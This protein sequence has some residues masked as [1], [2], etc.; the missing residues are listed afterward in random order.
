MTTREQYYQ[1]SRCNFWISKTKAF[2][3]NWL[4]L[5]SL[6]FR[7]ELIDFGLHCWTWFS[8]LFHDM[9]PTPQYSICYLWQFTVQCIYTVILCTYFC[10]S[11]TA[12][13]NKDDSKQR[14]YWNACSNWNC[15]SFHT[16]T[17]II[18]QFNPL[19][20][21]ASVTSQS[22]DSIPYNDDLNVAFVGASAR[23]A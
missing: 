5:K 6:V 10:W 8:L 16:L 23:S 12:W 18:R 7:L 15:C 13:V 1:K 3:H 9:T 20:K 14:L 22:R 11:L 17:D 2:W 21:G 19:L 4:L